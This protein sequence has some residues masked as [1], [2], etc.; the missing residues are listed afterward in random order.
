MQKK[1]EGVQQTQRGGPCSGEGWRVQPRPGSHHEVEGHG[2]FEE[3][4]CLGE[5][6]LIGGG[7]DG[8][9]TALCLYHVA[10]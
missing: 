8:D 6:N 5:V 4:G 3:L 7:H 10:A 2:G 9:P 1:V